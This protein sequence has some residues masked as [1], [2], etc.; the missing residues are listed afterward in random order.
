MIHPNRPLP[1]ALRPPCS[2]EETTEPGVD[3]PSSAE[4]AEPDGTPVGDGAILPAEGVS[5]ED[6]PP[7]GTETDELVE[8]ESTEVDPI[9]APVAEAVTVEFAASGRLRSLLHG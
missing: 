2:S 7:L 3:G 4:I 1:P 9:E 6:E 5:G 8:E